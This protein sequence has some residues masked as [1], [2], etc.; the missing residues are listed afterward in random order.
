MSYGETPTGTEDERG[1]T[2]GVVIRAKQKKMM[3]RNQ[4]SISKFHDLIENN[5][6]T[7]YWWMIWWY[8]VW[9]IRFGRVE[10]K[11]WNI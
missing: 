4:K 8:I 11:R 5:F 3:I 1:K 7:I 10:W 6:V 9:F 2:V